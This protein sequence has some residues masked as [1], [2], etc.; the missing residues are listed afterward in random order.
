[1]AAIGFCVLA[2]NA[3]AIFGLGVFLKPLIAEFGWDRG[4]LSGAFSV[5]ALIGGCLSLISGKLSDRYGPRILVTA[6]GLS[7]GTGFLLMS[8]ISLLWQVYVVWGLFIGIAL[9]CSVTPTNSTILRW[10]TEKRGIAIAIPLAGF[11]VGAVIVPLFIQWLISAYGW[12]QS[13]LILGFIPFIITVPLAQFMKRE[14]Q[15]IELK[16]YGESRLAEENEPTVSAIPKVSFLQVTKTA[17]FWVFGF[18]QFAF[19][20][21]MQTIIVHITPHA[22]DVGLSAII[23]ASILSIVAGGRIVGNLAIGLLSDRIGGRLT[24]IGCFILLTLTFAWLLFAK[25]SWMFYV[26]AMAFGFASGGIIPLLAVV[27]VELFGVEH[28]GT[29]LGAFFLFGS[30][31]GAIG[32]PSAGIIFDISG[33]YKAA[34]AVS[35]IIG[36]LAIILSLIL[37][38]YKG[39]GGIAVTNN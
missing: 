3:L 13:F 5:G 30:V 24:L 6:A 17:R 4:G 27:P 32:A 28:L 9:G 23:A 20:F 21:S 22:I 11:N 1:M 37:L 16:P 35:V 36:T 33:D 2:M 34:F 10:F 15:Q 26:F 38:R 39:K 14:P 19:G 12:R 25:E 29:I 8:Q 31:G 18:M 7:L